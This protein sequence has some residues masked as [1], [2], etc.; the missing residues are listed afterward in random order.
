MAQN[1]G[2]FFDSLEPALRRDAR[3]HVVTKRVT[4]GRELI[5]RGGASTEVYFVLQGSFSVR[6]YS[7]T[8]REV[9]M[10]TLGEGEMFG[11]L[12]A[13]DGLPRSASVVAESAALVEALPREEFLRCIKE[14]PDAA[15]WIIRLL[16]GKVRDGNERLFEMSALNVSSRVHCEL[17]RLARKSPRRDPPVLD[18]A[19]THSY[20]ASCIGTH[21]EA[22][23]REINELERL[24]IIVKGRRS[25]TFLD[26]PR[27][28]HLV[29]QAVGD[30]LS[31]P[32]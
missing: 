3:R 27:L 11:E 19:P 15:M 6:V 31:A 26:L 5:S 20:I 25:L 24:N 22:V 14:C 1:D 16:A 2:G 13:I 4:A 18:P 32:S 12:A 10:R 23:T 7:A 17:L 8:G 30:T 21:R 28:E 29:E 9:S